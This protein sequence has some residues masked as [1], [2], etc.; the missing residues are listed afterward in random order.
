LAQE[1]VQLKEFVQRE[2]AGLDV[3]IADNG[4]NLSVG[5]VWLDHELP[6]HGTA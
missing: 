5:Q 6:L 1:D 3:R 2:S 4:S